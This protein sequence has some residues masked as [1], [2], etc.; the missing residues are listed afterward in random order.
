MAQDDLASAE[1]LREIV[2]READAALGQIEAELS[3]H[4]AA[5]PSVIVAFRRPRPFDQPAEN[6][7]IAFRQPCFERA[8]D[9]DPQVGARRPAHD[10]AGKRR[11]EQF[12]IIGFVDEKSRR[13][14]AGCEFVECGGELLAVGAGQGCLGTTVTRQRG[15]NFAM[16]RG[17]SADEV[18][19]SRVL[20]AA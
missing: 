14:L 18:A 16:A 8:E 2:G 11:R 1:K 19:P 6:D 4:R 7:A 10:A 12:G 9:A 3:P 13:S 15:E 20:P 5:E 17:N